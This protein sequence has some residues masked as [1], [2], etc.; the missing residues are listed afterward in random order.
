[1]K[2]KIHILCVDDDVQI[3]FALV[4]LCESQGWSSSV[5]SN[6]QEAVK[7]FDRGGIDL[8]LMD[9]HLPGING[10]EGVRMLR[11]RSRRVPIIVFTVDD[12]QEVAD[13]FLKAGA[14][15]FA[16][17]PIRALDMIS[18]IRLHI[19]LLEKLPSEREARVEQKGI[20]QATTEL[21]RNC[22]SRQERPMTAGEIAGATGLAPQT[23]Y[24]Y[25]QY[26]VEDGEVTVSTAYGKVGRPRQ[27]YSA[28]SRGHSPAFAEDI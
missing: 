6:V 12:N 17:K 9:Y 22:L 23:A 5:A 16:L 18:R 8:I 13:A 26:L 28:V 7:M 14:T 11:M 3:R 19:R 2:N 20:S 4:A 21:L 15:D 24:R 25:L 27:Q 10:L 1:M